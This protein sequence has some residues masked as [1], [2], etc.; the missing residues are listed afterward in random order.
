[1]RARRSRVQT[2][3]RVATPKSQQLT[4]LFHQG[5]TFTFHNDV[6]YSK[7][8]NIFRS[9]KQYETRIYYTY[10]IRKYKHTHSQ[11]V[12]DAAS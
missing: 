9:A 10:L 7:S 11:V 1:M 8:Q 4:S 12:I 6:I 5:F 2:K 3:A